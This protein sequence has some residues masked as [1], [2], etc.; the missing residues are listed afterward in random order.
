MLNQQHLFRSKKGLVIYIPLM[1]FLVIEVI[2]LTN[3][4]YTGAVLL[5]CI[6]SFAFIP[7]LLNTYYI[8]KDNG[9]LKIRC[10]LL[11]NSEIAINTIKHINDTRSILSAPALSLDRIEKFYNKFDSIIVSP[12]D[13]AKFIGILQAINPAIQYQ[14]QIR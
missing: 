3:E 13:K 11:F 2:Y 12:D 9:V 6:I 5:L 4:V 7:A 1:I 10:G 8:I 14:E